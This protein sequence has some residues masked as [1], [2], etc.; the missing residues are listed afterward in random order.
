MFGF[1]WKVWC[2]WVGGGGKGREGGG[3]VWRRGEG[4][5]NE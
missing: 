4:G 2:E 5:T 3:G 1:V